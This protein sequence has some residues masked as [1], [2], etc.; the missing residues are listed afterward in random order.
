MEGPEERKTPEGATVMHFMFLLQMVLHWLLC[1]VVTLTAVAGDSRNC[2]GIGQP[3]KY[4][5]GDALQDPPDC[6]GPSGNA[7]PA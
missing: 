6:I 1:G 3:L 5:W 4:L 2:E 7:Y